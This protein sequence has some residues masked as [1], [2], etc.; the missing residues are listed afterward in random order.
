MPDHQVVVEVA[1]DV[2][3]LE[4]QVGALWRQHEPDPRPRRVL[5]GLAF[6]NGSGL[7]HTS[8]K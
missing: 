1:K 6:L 2:G 5:S 3:D 8:E 4:G 7:K